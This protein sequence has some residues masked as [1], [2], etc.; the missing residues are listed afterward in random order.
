MRIEPDQISVLSSCVSAPRSLLGQVTH[1]PE[2]TDE[3]NNN[4]DQN[5]VVDCIDEGDRD[6]PVFAAT[7][8][9]A[10]AADAPS[11]T[12]ADSVARDIWLV[13]DVRYVFILFSSLSRFAFRCSA[14]HF[15]A[16]A[17]LASA[18]ARCRAPSRR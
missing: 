3:N 11:T 14:S 16:N 17:K 15:F 18:V 9:I 8:D 7:L 2:N 13:V 6:A 5:D 1:A 10:L 4:K 12:D